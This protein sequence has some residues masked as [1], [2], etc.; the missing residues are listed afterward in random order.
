MRR[1]VPGD[2]VAATVVNLA[3]KAEGVVAVTATVGEVGLR[4]SPCFSEVNRPPAVRRAVTPFPAENSTKKMG[5]RDLSYRILGVNVAVHCPSP[6]LQTLVQTHWGRMDSD[7]TDGDLKYVVSRTGPSSAISIDRPGQP[8]KW[9]TDEGDFLYQLEADSN[10]AVQRIRKDLYF[11]HAAV[12]EVGGGAYLFVAKS[13][14][15]KST[16]LW[17]MLHHGWGYLSDELAPIDLSSMRVHAYPR[18][19]CLKRRPPQAYPLPDAT[20]QTPRTFHI[21][22]EHL[23]R[24]SHMVSCPLVAAYFVNHRPGAGDPAVRAITAGEASA[25]IYANTLNQLAHANAGLD[26]AV[27]IAKSIPCFALDSADLSATCALI[28]SHSI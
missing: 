11:L 5:S 16:T 24:V 6:E 1:P 20:V 19:L 21:P 4:D 9:T 18:A 26:A 15:G 7:Q 25:R 3:A 8:T 22:V 13:G 12:A 23:P 2:R 27:R 17:G 14:G 10:I 28:G